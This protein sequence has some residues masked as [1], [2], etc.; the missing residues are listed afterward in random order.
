MKCSTCSPA[1]YLAPE[2]V[3]PLVTALPLPLQST[4]SRFSCRLRA[5]SERPRAPTLR[6]QAMASSGAVR[7]EDVKGDLLKPSMVNTPVFR[8]VALAASVLAGAKSGS[9]L[10]TRGLAFLH[11]ST[12]AVSLGTLT[13]VTF[14]AGIVMFKNLPRQTFGKVQARL[15]PFYFA[16]TTLCTLLQL[17]TLSVLSGGAPLPRTPLIQ[18]AVGIAAGLA[19]W[20]VV[21]PHTTGIMFERYAL[22][23]AEG[24]RDNDRIKALYKTFG[25][26]HGFSSVLNLASLVAA[27]AYGWTL[28]GWL[29]VAA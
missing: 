15:F 7:N 11:L 1:L 24:P 2:G 23:N 20:L 13:W 28:A 3:R 29:H 14:I 19:N 6:V 21:E 18:L 25:A 22:E 4:T 9:V 27:V 12:Y 17:G 8:V 26:W 10:G 16:L 5:P